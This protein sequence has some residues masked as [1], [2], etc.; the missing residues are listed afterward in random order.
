MLPKLPYNTFL[1]LYVTASVGY[2]MAMTIRP[3]P[4][5]RI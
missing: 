5:A 4:P 3:S 1:D 2:L